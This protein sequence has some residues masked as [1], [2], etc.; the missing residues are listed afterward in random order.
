MSKIG[1]I[2]LQILAVT[3]FS[4]VLALIVNG[5]REEGLSLVVPFPPEYRCPS[6]MAEG[7]GT[8]IKDALQSFA[9]GEILFVDARPREA[10]EKGHIR[11]AISVPYSFV[12]ALPQEAVD[13]IKGH[14]TVIV[15][16]NSKDAERSRLMAGELSES[17]VK[18]VSYLE[19]G[20]LEWVKG[21]GSYSGQA[22]RAYE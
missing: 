16:C 15:Y 10:F 14:T 2:S 5:L 7:V 17:G 21:G 18:G 22:P 1:R 19:G 6:R 3:A 8:G 13:R 11:G 12:E 4:A 20:F 9:K